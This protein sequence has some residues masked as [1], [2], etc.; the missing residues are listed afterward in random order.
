MPPSKFTP[1]AAHRVCRLIRVGTPV[2][3]AAESIGVSRSTVYNWAARE[4]RFAAALEVARAQADAD[5]TVVLMRAVRRGSWRAAA[6]MLQWQWPERW[7]P[8]R[9]DGSLRGSARVRRAIDAR[10]R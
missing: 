3:V 2:E 8:R 1:D 4:A 6:W 7:A 9:R 5:L 10:T